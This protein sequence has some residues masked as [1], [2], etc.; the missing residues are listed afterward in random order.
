MTARDDRLT[1]SAIA[2]LAMCIATV[3]HEAL[4]HGSACLALG[5]HIT[6]LTSVYFDCSRH[7]VWL[8]ATGPL[9]NLVA[10]ALSWLALA[11]LPMGRPRLRLLLI[12][13]FAISLFW[14]AGYLLYSAVLGGGDNAIV[15]R[16]LFG[17]PEW[18]WRIGLFALGVALYAL[19]TRLTARAGRPFAERLR[20]LLRLSYIA[21]SIA[22]VI[23]TAFYAPDRQ[24]AT[25]QGALEIGASSIPLLLLGAPAAATPQEP[26]ITRNPTWIAFG[27][28][29]FAAFVATLGRGLP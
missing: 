2:L 3:F 10:A 14:A 1:V 26:A 17:A 21:A 20:P 16:I 9:G 28:L 18:P 27:A 13:T 23:A 29:I 7:N 25:I 5:G 24:A 19:G 11:M 12:L 6:Q 8:P 22:A 4:G 15:A